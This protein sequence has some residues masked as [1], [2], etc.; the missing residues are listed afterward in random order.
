[1]TVATVTIGAVSRC[2]YAVTWTGE[3]IH[4]RSGD[5]LWC[6]WTRAHAG[7]P[8]PEWLREWPRC[9]RCFR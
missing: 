9:E 7:P 5:H 6:D 8:N 4:R 1:M 3:R 2:R